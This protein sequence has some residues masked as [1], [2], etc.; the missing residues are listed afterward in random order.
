MMRGEQHVSREVVA[1]HRFGRIAAALRP[2]RVALAGLL[3]LVIALAIVAWGGPAASSLLWTALVV[4]AL[5]VGYACRARSP[6]ACPVAGH[7]ER[8]AGGERRAAPPG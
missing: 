2:S 4:A 3:I 8:A 7:G 5:G 6:A 1:H